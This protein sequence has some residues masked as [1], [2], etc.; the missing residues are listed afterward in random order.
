MNYHINNYHRKIYDIGAIT[1]TELKTANYKKFLQTHKLQYDNKPYKPF[2]KKLNTIDLLNNPGN[3]IINNNIKENMNNLLLE[4][5]NKRL[6]S[7]IIIQND[8]N[9]LLN[10]F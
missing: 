3:K 10:N 8:I 1:K 2:I 7:K 6:N 5:N 4:Q 9:I